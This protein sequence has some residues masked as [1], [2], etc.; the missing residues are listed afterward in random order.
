M[1]I[2]VCLA[3][4]IT[5]AIPTVAQSLPGLG[6]YRVEGE[7]SKTFYRGSKASPTCD[8]YVGIE[9]K[10]PLKPMFIFPLLN[11]GQGWFFVTAAQ[12]NSEGSAA[13]ATVYKIEKLYDQALN[14]E[15]FYQAGECQVTP[16]PTIRCTV[17]KDKDRTELARELVFAGSG[18]WFHQK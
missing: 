9:V 2:F 10:D 6:T 8:H 15:F 5:A 7:C 18:Q 1:K 16:G 3:T 14:A 4:L 13:N 17:W 11:G 12:P